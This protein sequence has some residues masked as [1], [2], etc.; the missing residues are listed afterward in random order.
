MITLPSTTTD[1]K[2]WE[3]G[4]MAVSPSALEITLFYMHYRAPEASNRPD[5]RNIILLL[6]ENKSFVL[7][8]PSADKSSHPL[9]SVLGAPLEGGH[10]MYTA[11]QNT[12]ISR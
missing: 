7:C 11:A 8:I 9:A 3:I 6:L 10:K 4:H 12:Y 5:F 1:T 2:T